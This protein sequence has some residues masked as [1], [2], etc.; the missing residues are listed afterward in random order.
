MMT[1]TA[2]MSGILAFIED[3]HDFVGSGEVIEYHCCCWG[4]KFDECEIR[5]SLHE[6]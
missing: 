6:R 1:P 4:F 3:C 2:M 5:K